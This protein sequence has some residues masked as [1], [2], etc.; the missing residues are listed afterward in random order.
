MLGESMSSKVGCQSPPSYWLGTSNVAL[1]LDERTDRLN[2]EPACKRDIPQHL[3][4][5]ALPQKR[6]ATLA[7]PV[8][9][10][11]ALGPHTGLD[12]QTMSAF[13]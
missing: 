10:S 12:L 6:D 1:N 4:S 3:G 2:K 7:I 11:G 5:A 9:P 13:A 8:R